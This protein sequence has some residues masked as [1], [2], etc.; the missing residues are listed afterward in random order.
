MLSGKVYI[1]L[2]LTYV[3][4]QVVEEK[5]KVMAK[6]QTVIPKKVRDAA[7]IEVGDVLRWRYE[8]GDIIVRAPRRVSKPSQKL[9]GLIPSSED[10]VEKI[11]KV[12][13]G[14]LEKIQP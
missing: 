13:D 3:W 9:Y 5:S 10:A 6:W 7:N 2:H 11:E 12:R 14:R 1:A 8:S 4:C